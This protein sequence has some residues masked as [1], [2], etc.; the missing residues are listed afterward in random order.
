MSVIRV[1]SDRSEVASRLESFVR[2]IDGFESWKHIE[3][4]R[5][6]AWFLHKHIGQDHFSQADIKACYDILH[7]QKTNPSTFLKALQQRKPKEVIKDGWESYYLE[8]RVRKRFDAIY[9]GSVVH[10]TPVTEQ[11]LPLSV[12][13]STRGYIERIVEQANG[14]YERHMFD[15]CAVMMRKLA[16]IEVYEAKGRS[17]D[18][19]N[20]NG[21]F[22][23][24]GD[25][26]QTMLGDNAW[27]PGRE[28]KK[29]LP[30]IKSLGDRSA[31][32]RRF[33]ARQGDVD[34]VLHGF[35]VVVEEL[36]HLS[37]LK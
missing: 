26:I 14:C 31:H 3:K 25:L 15:A 1:S 36:L 32:G 37:N 21:D 10:P 33:T 11:V 18:L 4:I 2:G 34:K 27:N 24:L 19:K 29:F 35:R 16:I 20:N 28:T 9:G 7:L 22:K 5:F 23:M 6:F 13:R 30:E 12:V 8:R 17:A